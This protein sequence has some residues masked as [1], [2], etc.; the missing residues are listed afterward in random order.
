MPANKKAPPDAMHFR[1]LRLENVRAFGSAQ[2][3]EFIDESGRISRWNLILGENGVGKTTLMQALAVM[4]PVSDFPPTRSKAELSEHE[5]DEIMHFIRRGARCKAAMTAV[6]EASGRPLKIKVE[7]TGQID[8]LDSA[9]FPS[10]KHE[11][12]SEGPLIIK[13]GADRHIRRDISPPKE[14]DAPKTPFSEVTVLC[15][16]EEILQQLDYAV[17]SEP[18]Q[19]NTREKLRLE[20]LKTVVASLLPGHLTAKDIDIRGPRRNGKDQSG[21]LVQTPSGSTPFADLSLGYQTMLAWAVDLASRLFDAF[22]KSRKPL[23]ESAIVLIDEVELHLH[24]QWQ[25]EIRQR[26]LSNFPK[27][28]FI[29]TTHSPTAAQETLAEGGN[30]TVLQW[31]GNEAHISNRPIPPDSWRYDQLLVS[32]LFGLGSDR[33][34]QAE[35]VLDERLKLL[36]T[37]NR[38]PK[39]KARLHELNE[40]VG[41]LPTARS[42]LAQ[43][44]EDLTSQFVKDFPQSVT[45]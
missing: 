12:R 15:D 6:F 35:A 37:P 8:K 19:K 32:D 20:A 22:P 21:V 29:A 2:N 27:L 31:V 1:S 33:S 9:N 25:R 44:F 23:S 30:V 42:P 7:I 13:Y 11:L 39:Q 4:V 34:M 10:A 38:S 18:D 45:R 3:L 5:N 26:L 28:Q 16:A 14:T 17:R 43:R 41:H 40:L 36:E 24:P